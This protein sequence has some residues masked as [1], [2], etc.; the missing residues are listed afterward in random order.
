M[1]ER[2]RIDDIGDAICILFF[3]EGLLK[4]SDV[5]K[6]DRKVHSQYTKY[7]S[8]A[9]LTEPL[10]IEIEDGVPVFYFSHKYFFIVDDKHIIYDWK[11]TPKETDMLFQMASKTQKKIEQEKRNRKHK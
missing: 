9:G 8:W 3:K 6:V 4:P 11:L 10:K 1:S 7:C 2:K 5:T